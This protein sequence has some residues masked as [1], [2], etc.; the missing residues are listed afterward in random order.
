MVENY[1]IMN[2]LAH[3]RVMVISVTFRR[4]YKD[5]RNSVNY[6]SMHLV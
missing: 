1:E 4:Y 3:H 5:Y 6:N 2:A